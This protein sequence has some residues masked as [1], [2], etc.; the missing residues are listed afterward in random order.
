MLQCGSI[1]FSKHLSVSPAKHGTIVLTNVMSFRVDLFVFP[2]NKNHMN[3]LENLF[4]DLL[5][6]A[7]EMVLDP[8]LWLRFP[9][10]L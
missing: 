10:A 7:R 4:I 8:G 6:A 1:S 5:C 3:C 2:T 9:K